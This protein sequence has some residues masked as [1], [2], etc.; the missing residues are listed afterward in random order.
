MTGIDQ[1]DVWTGETETIRE[2][3]IVENHQQANSLYQK[4]LI[5]DRYKITVYMNHEYGELF[6]LKNDPD[7]LVNLWDNPAYSELK[8]KLLLELMQ[9]DMKQEPIL[10]ERTAGA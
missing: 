2:N 5:T 7:E 1:K 8:T 3:V 6:D 9:S 4:Q 10:V